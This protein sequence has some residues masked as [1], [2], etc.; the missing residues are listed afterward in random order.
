M[1]FSI[2]TILSLASFVLA[3]VPARKQS[4]TPEYIPDSYIIQFKDTITMSAKGDNAHFKWLNEALAKENVKREAGA[5]KYGVKSKY[6]IPG[7][8]GYSGTFSKSIVDEIKAR[9]EVVDVTQDAIV[10]TQAPSGLMD[11]LGKSALVTPVRP[12]APDSLLS[13][14]FPCT[15]QQLSTVEDDGTPPNTTE[16]GW[17]KYV[18]DRYT[19]KCPRDSPPTAYVIDSGI[20]SNHPDYAG[21]AENGF[22]YK[23]GVW[24]NE[25]VCG[26]GTHVAGII[27]GTK[28]G[29]MKSTRLIGVKVLE[30]AD[31]ECSGTWSGVIAGVNWAIK[32]AKLKN[33]LKTSVINM[34]LGGASYPPVNK[35]VQ[36]AIDNGMTVVTAAGNAY[37]A[38]SC[39]FSPAAVAEAIT[40][41][42]MSINEQV[43]PFSNGGCCIDIF[44]PGQN[45]Q[46][47]YLGN[48]TRLLSG[49]SMAAPMV[50]GLV[51]YN[52]CRWGYNSP[53]SDRRGLLEKYYSDNGALKYFPTGSFDLCA[54]S[55][56]MYNRVAFNRANCF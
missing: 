42:S 8:M 23:P 50:A 6:Q 15:E 25:D 1:K 35:A 17:P 44:A 48:V 12:T 30:G 2:I 24:P 7:F 21:R 4:K 19:G 33:A 14:R 32:D 55:A 40:V 29:V 3:G 49:T 9:N 53:D 11:G 45:I 54:A 13:Q 18:Y 52:K 10:R 36:A 31:A 46:S 22:N 39:E 41:G 26:H 28:H 37:G 43:S 5:P 27:G 16:S 51:L 56:D 34:S 38:D 47:A 20:L